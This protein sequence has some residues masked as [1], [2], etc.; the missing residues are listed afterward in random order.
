MS[1]SDWIPNG[2]TAVLLLLATATDL[3]T[4]KIPNRLTV[5][6]AVLG[7][8]AQ[9]L[10]GGWGGAQ[11]AALGWLL[12]FAILALPCLLGWMGGGDVKLLA[13]VGAA[14]GPGLVLSAGLYGM[15]LGGILALVAV[16]RARAARLASG[17]TM[18]RVTLPYAPALALG[19]LV[20]LIAR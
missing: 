19:T 11:Q 4:R 7:L 18:R 5:S 6:A 9:A 8:A 16:W 13:A 12:G 2:L 20:A 10:L 3:R 14:Q 1:W 15:L 17:A